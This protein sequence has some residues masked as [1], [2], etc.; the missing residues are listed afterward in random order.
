MI[1]EI[2]E[3]FE[4]KTKQKLLIFYFLTLIFVFVEVFLIASLYPI[5]QNFF[6]EDQNQNFISKILNFFFVD[7]KINQKNLVI[8]VISLTIFRFLYFIFFNYYKNSLLQNIQKK[9][10]EKIFN[11]FFFKEYSDYLNYNSSILIRDVVNETQTFKKYINTII[12]LLVEILLILS[13]SIFLISI[14]FKIFISIL[15]FLSFIGLVY[16]FILKG[17]VTSLGAKKILISKQI[18]KNVSESFKFFEIIKIQKKLDYF[19]KINSQN[20]SN[21]NDVLIKTNLLQVLPRIIVETLFFLIV[22]S[23]FLFISNSSN[24]KIEVSILGIFFVSFL[25][26]YPSFVRIINSIQDINLFKKSV[27][28]IR[29]QIKFVKEKNNN[30]LLTSIDLKDAIKIEDFSFNFDG[31]NI[32][33]NF[34]FELKKNSFNAIIGPSGSGKSTLIKI[35]LGLLKPKDIKTYADSKPIEFNRLTSYFKS[36]VGYAGQNSLS[37]NSSLLENITLNENKNLTEDNSKKLELSFI[38]AGLDEFFSFDKDLDKIIV[39]DGKNISGGQLQRISLARALFF[40]KGILIFDEICSSLD[41]ESEKK[42]INILKNLSKNYMIL[43]ITHRNNF[44]DMFD[45]IIKIDK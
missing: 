28:G 17:T 27:A 32:F 6:S 31:N 1:K 14:N 11:N 44:F 38:S 2:F 22:V 40:S 5:F 19:S 3:S 23:V 35:L 43:Y 21:L 20:Y 7:Y 24:L 41:V 39:E 8:F 29:D 33:K 34:N 4:K 26:I 10:A 25:R 13:V 18:I 36:K 15:L 16:F 42:I 9:I 37:L 12:S 45:Q 30:K